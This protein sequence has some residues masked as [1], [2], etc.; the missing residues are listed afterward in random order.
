MRSK[1][2][3]SILVCTLV[4]CQSCSL[5]DVLKNVPGFG[6]EIPVIQVEQLWPKVPAIEGAKKTDA[7]MPAAMYTYVTRLATLARGP[8]ETMAF[9]TPRTVAEVRN[10]YSKERLEAAGWH[11]NLG[12]FQPSEGGACFLSRQDAEWLGK[13]NVVIFVE[14]NT[15]KKETRIFYAKF[16]TFSEED[17][18]KI[19]HGEE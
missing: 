16:D 19:L 10:F 14:E 12:C 13:G 5:Y 4:L 11:P 15:E 17:G 1:T 9:T 6:E 2:V 8:I 7:P 3:S 18:R